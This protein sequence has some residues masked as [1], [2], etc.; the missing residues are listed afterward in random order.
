MMLMMFDDVKRRKR[1]FRVS[2]D[3]LERQLGLMPAYAS[4]ERYWHQAADG[5][6][7]IGAATDDALTHD[8]LVA[9]YAELERRWKRGRRKL[10]AQD[11]AND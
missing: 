2:F 8:L 9:A 4:E 5:L 11:D 1:A 10:D 6:N 3:Y 7:D